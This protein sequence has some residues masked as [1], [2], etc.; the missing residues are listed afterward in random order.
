MG[1]GCTRIRCLTSS[2][3]GTP[4]MCC[5]AAMGF[6]RAPPRP[7]SSRRRGVSIR[8]SRAPAAG[9]PGRDGHEP[10][11]PPQVSPAM[12]WRASNALSHHHRDRQHRSARQWDGMQA[13]PLSQQKSGPPENVR[14]CRHWVR[15]GAAPTSQQSALRRFDPALEGASC[16]LA[17]AGWPR[18]STLPRGMPDDRDRQHRSA[19]DG[20]GCRRIRYLTSSEVGR[21]T[22][23]PSGGVLACGR[24]DGRVKD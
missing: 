17:G 8:R 9:W 20:M 19:G 10:R 4:E 13:H 6:G 5:L 7:A 11:R 3:V 12:T 16:G 23:P 14:C 21:L 24:L 18:A 1:W 2:E 15:P 22:K